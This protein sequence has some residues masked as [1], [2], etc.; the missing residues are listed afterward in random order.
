MKLAPLTKLRAGFTM[1]EIIVVMSI[2]V[3][4]IG[5]GFA[6]FSFMDDEDPFQ[7]PA[8]KL[9]EMSKFAIQAAV[10]QHRSLTIA[11]DKKG[12]GLLGITMPDGSYYSVP[13]GMKVFILRMGARD[14]E[15]AE[16]HAWR[17]GEQGICEP[18]KIRFETQTGNRD[19]AFHPLTGAPVE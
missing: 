2:M 4:I 18:I 19:L 16:G 3:L 14:W 17:F 12:F 9:T 13:T 15:K 10:L 8:Q 7:K 11:F 6:S 5:I 1:L